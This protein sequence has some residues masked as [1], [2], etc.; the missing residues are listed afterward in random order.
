MNQGRRGFLQSLMALPFVGLL[1]GKKQNSGPDI[2]KFIPCPTCRGICM[3][4]W[5]PKT[6]TWYQ[7]ID[8][9]T[10]YNST[11]RTRKPRKLRTL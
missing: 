6:Q 4:E 3:W 1:K 5:D 9:T 8:T 11:Y 7:L 2:R 10:M